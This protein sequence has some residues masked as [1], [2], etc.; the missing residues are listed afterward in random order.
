MSTEAPAQEKWNDGEK[1]LRER[2]VDAQERGLKV[3]RRT[4]WSQVAVA[5]AAIVA[6][7]AAAFAAGQARSAVNVAE[8]GLQAQDAENQLSTAV[9]ALGGTTAA[10]RVAGVTLLER[11]VAEQLS[12]ATTEQSRQNAYGLYLSAII[13]LANYLRSGP[14]LAVHAPCPTVGADVKYAADELKTLL[15][16]RATGE[17]P[18]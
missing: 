2:E 6:S 17:R 5:V 16:M 9:T 12:G 11:N 3:Q 15:D 4:F 14:P 18:E 8:Q 10:Q 13:V 7:L 1:D